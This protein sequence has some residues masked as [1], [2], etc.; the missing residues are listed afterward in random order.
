V[1]DLAEMRRIL[2][3][4][5]WD[6]PNEWASAVNQLAELSEDQIG[7]LTRASEPAAASRRERGC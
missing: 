3:G 6:S 2:C 1:R 7:T 4:H 5:V